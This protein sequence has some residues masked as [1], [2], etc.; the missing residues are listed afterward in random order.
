M[1]HLFVDMLER[2]GFLIALAFVFSRSRWMRSSM[3]YQGEQAHQW[4][5]VVFFSLY[6]I[7]GTYSGVTVTPYSYQPAP[8]IGEVSPTAAIANSR[9]IGVVIAG[10]LGGVKSGLIVGVIAGLHRYSLGGFVAVACMLAPVAQG[11]MAGLFRNAVK[12]RFR[13][14]A[15]AKPAFAVGLLAEAVQMALILLLAKPWNE[16]LGLVALIGIPQIVANG[17]GVSLFFIVYH[18]MESEEDRIGTEHARKA[19][20]IADLTMPLWRLDFDRAVREVARTLHEETKAVGAYFYKNDTEW[21]KEGR[22]TPY[23]VDLPM[24]MQNQKLIGR[25]RLFYERKQEDTPSRRRMMT[26]LARLISQQYAFVEAERQGQ[27]LADAEIRSL[28][29]QMSPHF[30][31]NVLNTVKSFIR[32]KP[33]EARQL[34][35]HLSKF[36]RKNIN[37]SSKTLVSVRDELE[38]VMSYLSLTKARLGDQLEFVTDIDEAA[39]DCRIPPFT[40]QPLVENAI[41]H[42]LQNIGRPGMIRLGVKHESYGGQFRA[43]IT[44]EDNG[45][46]MGR[47]VPGAADEHAG[48]ALRNIVQRLSYHYGT[49]QPLEIESTPGKGTKVSFWVR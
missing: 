20:H 6:A 23:W 4:R 27:L 48:V 14:A 34:I 12:R 24:E 44:V 17:I 39:L 38:L 16:A 30:L 15:S 40:I 36:L 33:E 10:L 19:L 3:S 35:T 32:T 28:Q 11:I 47:G 9:S 7:L 26:T 22:K 37:G 45:T 13:H 31:F 1:L 21:V 8:W 49:E 41:V 25:F 5:F 42:G 2:V 18:T 46:G 43:R 29:A